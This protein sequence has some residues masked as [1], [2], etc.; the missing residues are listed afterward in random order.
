[1]KTPAEIYCT[2]L[3]KADPTMLSWEAVSQEM[4]DASTE[5]MRLAIAAHEKAQWRE[6]EDEP[7]RYEPI[8]VN[9]RIEGDEAFQVHEGFWSG[10]Y[11]MP[12]RGQDLRALDSRI[13]EVTGWREMP[14]AP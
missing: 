3:R 1:M 7:E 2:A 12:V 6:P 10:N 13:V 5:A 4:R 11:W 8:L 14:K 9:G